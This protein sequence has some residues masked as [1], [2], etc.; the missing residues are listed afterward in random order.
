MTT[1]I[2]AG[3]LLL[4][5]GLLTLDLAVLNRRPHAISPREALAWT[6]F[7]VGLALVFCAGVYVVYGHGLFGPGQELSAGAAAIQ[8]LTA[9]LVEESLSLD[10]VFVIA[11]VIQFFN[12]PAAYQ[13][14]VLFWGIA[15]ALVMRG[16]MIL[17]GIA[18]IRRMEWLVY[19]FGLILLLTAARMLF[20]KEEGIDPGKNLA[21]RAFRKLWPVT[22][23][24][25][26]SRFFV[27]EAGRRAAT[28][29]FVALIVIESADLLFA[30]DSIPAV[31]AITRD[32]FIAF[33]SNAFAILGLR[34]L[35]FALAAVMGRFHYL[36]LSL[37]LV[38]GFVGVKMILSRHDHLPVGVSLGVITALLGAGI[39]ASL[40]KERKG[41]RVQS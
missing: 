4:M 1:A 11:V 19:P 3:S 8:W 10:N 32:P 13:H 24:I 5:A 35:Y 29:L 6:A 28:P 39:G 9:Y 12:V 7:W 38:L 14:G 36:K 30:V 22:E 21:V 15:G 40:V 27:R 37:V 20:M 18:A 31:L 23:K 34:S 26:G 33:T 25:D 17:L 2:W 16:T 41:L